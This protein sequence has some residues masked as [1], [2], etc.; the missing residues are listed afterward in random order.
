M[1]SSILM[2]SWSV[3]IPYSI[4]RVCL[5]CSKLEKNLYAFMKDFAGLFVCQP[6]PSSSRAGAYWA[7][8]WIYNLMPWHLPP[9]RTLCTIYKDAN[10]LLLMKD[11]ITQIPME[12]LISKSF[13]LSDSFMISY[14][15]LECLTWNENCIL[16]SN[17]W[18]Y[19]RQWTPFPMEAFLL[20]QFMLEICISTMPI[21]DWDVSTNIWNSWF[22][23]V[24]EWL[25]LGPTWLMI[26][27]SS[28]R[29]VCAMMV[30]G[31]IWWSL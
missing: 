1:I 30:A 23:L 2:A 15:R 16:S 25:G 3:Y 11:G 14:N 8:A 4:I 18:D 10:N 7:K 17:C 27:D 9:L 22:P 5:N 6:F 20:Y 26:I 19:K 21:V 13:P 24:V 28:P 29:E 12:A 31:A